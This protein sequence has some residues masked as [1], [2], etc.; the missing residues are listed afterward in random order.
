[1]HQQDRI[2]VLAS[3]ILI[4]HIPFPI[5]IQVLE[6]FGMAKSRGNFLLRLWRFGNS[7]ARTT[8]TTGI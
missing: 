3:N 4:S 6:S 5:S 8:E 7:R 2:D 1:M